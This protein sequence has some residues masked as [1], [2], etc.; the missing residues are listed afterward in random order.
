MQSK[1]FS[2]K[3]ILIAFIAGIVAS[4][5]IYLINEMLER[6]E[7]ILI[8]ETNIVLTKQ[9]KLIYGI[10][11]RLKIPIINVDSDIEN[12]GITTGGIMDVPSSPNNVGWFLLGPRPGEIGSAVLTGHFGW[13]NNLPAVFDNLNKLQKGDKLYVENEKG[14][15][16]VF[17]VR[18]LRVYDEKQDASNVFVSND[19]IAHMNLIT[20]QGAWNKTKK[21][22]SERLVIFTDKE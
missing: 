6:K 15:V 21:S 8:N 2:K 5:I 14:V 4:S 22:Y 11:T 9:K 13:K 16:I 20:C 10:P 1:I 18:E 3:I 19:G 7:S 12:V 17:I